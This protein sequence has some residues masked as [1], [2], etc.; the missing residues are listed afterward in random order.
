MTFLMTSGDLLK[1]ILETFIILDQIS[2]YRRVLR[3]CKNIPEEEWSDH[4]SLRSPLLH[5]PVRN[6]LFNPENVF[7]KNLLGAN[8][9]YQDYGIEII[10]ELPWAYYHWER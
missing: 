8:K 3:D 2:K 5:T 4:L 7:T 1:T 9:K 6:S 10:K